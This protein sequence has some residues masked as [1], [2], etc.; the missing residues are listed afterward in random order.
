MGV[1]LAHANDVA[2][3]LAPK[4]NITI[5]G[6]ANYIVLVPGKRGTKMELLVFVAL[7]LHYASPRHNVYEAN[8]TVVGGDHRNVLVEEVD[9]GDFAAARELAIIILYLDGPLQFETLHVSFLAL[10]LVWRL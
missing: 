8:P 6:S 2:F 10:E 5:F 1:L 7:D 3:N 4:I 9:A